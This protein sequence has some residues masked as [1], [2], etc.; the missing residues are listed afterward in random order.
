MKKYM[1]YII[2]TSIIISF[3][4]ILRNKDISINGSGKWEVTFNE[5]M[6]SSD[7]HILIDINEKRLYAFSKGKQLAS[8]PIASGRPGFP[9][10]LGDFIIIQKD[11]WGEGFGTAWM[12][13]NVPW[14][15]Y[16][17]HGTN[18]PQSIGHAASSGCIRM[19]NNDVNKLYK[20]V[21]VGTPVKIIGGAYGL[22]GNGYRILSPGDRGADVYIVQ[23]RLKK[24]GFYNGRLDGIYGM[25]MENALYKF[26]KSKKLTISN[27]IT[28]R[29]YKELGL[30]LFE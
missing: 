18:K 25:G 15:I 8:Y 6:H 17:I 14:G 19:R 1:P 13:I 27:K 23:D 9:S 7:V 28:E 10:P 26:L 3:I 29:I 20:M 22:L 21:K 5:S 11:R 16:G 4:F 24:L 2:I 30:I 12:K